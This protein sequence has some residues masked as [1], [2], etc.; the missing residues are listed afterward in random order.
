M[1]SKGTRA[2]TLIFQHL[3]NQFFIVETLP[4]LYITP[5]IIQKLRV[6]WSWHTKTQQTGYPI[7]HGQWLSV[8][9]S[10]WKLF[11]K[12]LVWT[13]C[14]HANIESICCHEIVVMLAKMAELHSPPLTS[15]SCITQHP[16]LYWMCIYSFVGA[17]YVPYCCLYCVNM[18]CIKILRSVSL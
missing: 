17:L 14:C 10:N 15:V 7:L 5:K 18:Q 8:T 3:E 2:N 12:V 13:L 6:R 9:E 11:I 16:M 4:I 1:F